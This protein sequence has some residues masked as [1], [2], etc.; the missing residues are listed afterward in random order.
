[1]N[2]CQRSWDKSD[3]GGLVESEP[4]VIINN[5]I[6]YAVIINNYIIHINNY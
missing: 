2:I 5:Y 3:H 1:M 4:L 6:S